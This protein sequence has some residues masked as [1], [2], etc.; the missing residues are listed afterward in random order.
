[1]FSVAVHTILFITRHHPI[2]QV[3]P[4]LLH[5]IKNVTKYFRD[6]DPS[7]RSARGPP[8]TASKSPGYSKPY[9]NRSRRSDSYRAQTRI[10]AILPLPIRTSR[11]KSEAVYDAT[12][13]GLPI[14]SLRKWRIVGRHAARSATE[15]SIRS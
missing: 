9:P 7:P 12:I 10:I 15:I 3:C 8:T 6:F 5:I 13:A 2:L 1:M 4:K 11:V 14:V